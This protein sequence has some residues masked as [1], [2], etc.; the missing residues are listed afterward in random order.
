VFIRSLLFQKDGVK[1]SVFVVTSKGA[2]LVGSTV[3]G[4]DSGC[5]APPRGDICDVIVSKIVEGK[6]DTMYSEPPAWS[7]AFLQG[8]CHVKREVNTIPD[9]DVIHTMAHSSIKEP[10][11]ILSIIAAFG[12]SSKRYLPFM[13]GFFAAQR[14]GIMIDCCNLEEDGSCESLFQQGCQ[15]TGGYY[16]RPKI[17][18]SL[19]EYLM[20][21]FMADSSVRQLLRYP[22]ACGVDFRASCFCHKK[23]VDTGYVC[24][25]CLSVFCEKMNVCLTCGSAF[26]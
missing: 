4:V 15:L 7:A 12:D 13:N 10:C 8:L 5:M 23:L 16:I 25:V 19:L 22:S 9:G 14:D 20:T 1:V 2:V 18:D 26:T 11:R 3:P 6:D 21:A 24:S 17:P